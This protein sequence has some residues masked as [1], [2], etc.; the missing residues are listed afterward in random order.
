VMT[1]EERRNETSS[2]NFKSCCCYHHHC[3]HHTLRLSWGDKAREWDLLA[4][5]FS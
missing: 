4:R 5:L 3:R 1:G 2:N